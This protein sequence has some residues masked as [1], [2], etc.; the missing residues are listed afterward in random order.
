MQHSLYI[1]T[2]NIVFVEGSIGCGKSTVIDQLMLKYSNY[3]NVFVIPENV[4]KWT[5]KEFEDGK[6]IL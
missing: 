6:N 1:S 5:E 3:S 4:S 2:R